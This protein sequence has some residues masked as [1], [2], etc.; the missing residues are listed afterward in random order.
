MGVWCSHRNVSMKPER[1]VHAF[2]DHKDEVIAYSKEPCNPHR[3]D[4]DE[5]ESCLYHAGIQLFATKFLD[6]NTKFCVPVISFSAGGEITLI[7]VE[8]EPVNDPDPMHVGVFKKLT[9]RAS[10]VFVEESWIRGGMTCQKDLY[11]PDVV[12]VSLVRCLHSM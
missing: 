2:K 12:W 11:N 4:C 3:D 1:T 10:L 5:P 8:L 7:A 9:P 6:H